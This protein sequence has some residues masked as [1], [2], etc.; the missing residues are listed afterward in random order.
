MNSCTVVKRIY[1]PGYHI[2]W[3][4]GKQSI[5]KDKNNENDEEIISPTDEQTFM[6][7]NSFESTSFKTITDHAIAS[8]DNNSIIIYS[9]KLISC[10]EKNKIDLEFDE[11]DEIYLKNGNIIKAKIIEIGV[12]EIKYKNCNNLNGPLISISKSDVFMIIYSD[13]NKEIFNVEKTKRNDLKNDDTGNLTTDGFATASLVLGILSVLLPIFVFG[14][15]A[16]VFGGISLNRIDKNPDK[17]KGKGLAIAGYIC[18]LIG[19]IIGFIVLLGS[20]I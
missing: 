20:L 11:C 14:I 1:R 12:S 2:D 15:L 6:A 10:N 7:T 8:S 5:T 4:I 16:I 18:G 19:F 3:L 9:D 17:Y 13:G